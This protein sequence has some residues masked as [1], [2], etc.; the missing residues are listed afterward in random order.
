MDL[1]SKDIGLNSHGPELNENPQE[2]NY[3]GKGSVS[4]YPQ[5]HVLSMC[6]TDTT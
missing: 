1:E 5:W 3:L 6:L 2:A 4:L